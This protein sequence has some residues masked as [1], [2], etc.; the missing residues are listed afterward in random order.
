MKKGISILFS[1]LILIGI[2]SGCKKPDG[3]SSGTS[4]SDNNN[5]EPSTLEEQFSGIDPTVLLDASSD[6]EYE[7]D[8]TKLGKTINNKVSD[9]NF[10]GGFAD[11][12]GEEI[13]TVDVNYF[14]TRY[15]FVRNIHFMQATGGNAN[16]DLIS[17][18]IEGPAKNWTDATRL[19]TACK[20]VVRQGLKPYVKTGNVPA[21]LS[22]DP[23]GGVFGVNCKPPADYDQY[24]DYIKEIMIQLKAEFGEEELRTWR[25]GVFTEYENYDWFYA[26][27][28]VGADSA[29][30]FMKIYD[31]TVAAIQ[32]VIGQEIEVG[33]HS[34]T[35]SEGGWK[36]EDFIEHCAIGTNY[37]TGK[38][39]TRLTFLAA[40]YYDQ[41][42]NN[43]RQSRNLTFT[44]NV[45]RQKAEAVGLK[46]LMFGIDEGRLFAGMDGKELTNRMVGHTYQASYDARMYKT[47][48]DADIDYFANWAYGTSLI[49]G[50]DTVALHVANCFYKMVG[51]KVC[52]VNK[53]KDLSNAPNTLWEYDAFAGYDAENKKLY[54]MAYDFDTTYNKQMHNIM[55]F[56]IKG[57]DAMGKNLTVKRYVIDDNANFWDEWMD[58]C[59]EEGYTSA[60]FDWSMDSTSVATNSLSG[61]AALDFQMNEKT[62]K[63]KAKLIGDKGVATVTNGE[64][65]LNAKVGHHGVVFYE[66]SA[67]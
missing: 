67:E 4:S 24:Y 66:I 20:A 42:P 26:D 27:S 64:L 56:K 33:A 8:I 12:L 45:L 62:F 13:G 57:L 47:M 22:T 1:M 3:T 31:Y 52:E 5:N 49:G 15:P 39:G 35:C 21:A 9:M 53:I 29:E 17:G 63:E 10:F 32:D 51:A 60:D 61:A 2:A 48:I 43:I 18:K 58:I 6:A 54:I 36:E 40:S 46:D 14:K 19:I 50:V 7:I 55:S 28:R 44:I 30:A 34:M 16:R 25:W 37:K 65:T 59:D 23:K 11:W 38:K 41:A